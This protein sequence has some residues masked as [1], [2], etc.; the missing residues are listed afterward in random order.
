MKH[1]KWGTNWL[2]D[3]VRPCQFWSPKKNSIFEIFSVVCGH[4][5]FERPLLENGPKFEVTLG[6]DCRIDLKVVFN[7][8][9]AD[10]FFIEPTLEIDF[11][12]AH[13]KHWKTLVFTFDWARGVWNN[14]GFDHVFVKIAQN[15]K[16]KFTL[17]LASVLI[18][19][20]AKNIFF[21][22]GQRRNNKL[23]KCGF[24]KIK[25]NWQLFIRFSLGTKLLK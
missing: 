2:V 23:D 11:I 8:P 17:I 19:I 10:G 14:E 6:A 21:F 22:N 7:H 24:L 12:S 1:L 3:F 5:L 4:Q 25:L 16:G 15:L 9:V 20:L 13:V 18:T